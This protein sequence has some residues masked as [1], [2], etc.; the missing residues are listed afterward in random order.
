M[1]TEY[2]APLI[3]WWWL[4]VIAT[5]IAGISAYYTTIP[6]PYMYEAKTTLMIGRFISSLNPSQDEINLSLQLA[7]TYSDVIS[8][9][10]VRVATMKALGLNDLPTYI[11]RPLTNGPF[12]QITVTYSDPKIAQA[13]SN[14]LAN[15]LIMST[16]ASLKL[17]EQDTQNF[18]EQQI[19][20][21]ETKIKKT[22]EEIIQKQS[23]LSTLSSAVQISQAQS[24]LDALDTR[25]T[26]LQAIYSN[27]LATMP[28]GARNQLSI[29]ESAQL[30]K[31]PVGPNKT[32]IIS[33]ASLAG[34]MIASIAA[35][36]IEALDTTV[37]SPEEVTK[38]LELPI[39]GR[40]SRI[41]HRG[42]KHWKVVV[43]D[44]QST[45]SEDFRLL[46]TNLEF[47]GVDKRIKTYM[48]SSSGIGD[49]KSTI[50]TYL[51]MVMAMGEKSVILV[52]ADLRRPV[53]SDVLELG[54]CLG[55]SDALS[56]SLPVSQVLI[57]WKEND[58]LSILPAGTIP[59][60]PTELL[61]SMRMAHVLEELKNMADVIIL[62]APPFIISDASI[63][64]SKAD[65][66]LLVVRNGH[67]HRAAVTA[68]QEQLK[69]VGSRVLGVVM[70]EV[71]STNSYYAT[72]YR[73]PSGSKKSEA[74]L[75]EAVPGD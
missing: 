43:D 48:V 71:A 75:K 59:P 60:N 52:D 58:H 57:P 14:E 21:V 15:Q 47:F 20:D 30:P 28:Q 53:L 7:Q 12:M 65:G 44:L 50:A 4:L 54:D 37:K 40:I 31:I 39:I 13:V 2:Y 74:A 56:Q 25:L 49:G 34:L 22:Q 17:T 33:L 9:E 19:K 11:A 16:P 36:S 55:L 51:A 68:M 62:D 29:Y 69:R 18:L 10:P 67:S 61:G 32:L 35:Y 23:V 73:K 1:R 27:M 3:K 42:S 8:R 70:N 38:I 72:K 45:I 66:I 26:S 64:A 5:V 24:E 41:S 6:L 63:L 46:R